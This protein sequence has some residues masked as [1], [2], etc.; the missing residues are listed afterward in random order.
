MPDASLSEAIRALARERRYSPA[1]V[2]RWLALAEP[3]ARACFELADGLKLGENQLRDLWQWADDI[4]ARD[5]STLADVFG[6]DDIRRVMARPLGRADR[7]K[8]VKDALRRRRFPQLLA[9][10]EKLAALADKLALPRGVRL[11]WPDMLEGDSLRIEF[12]AT[13]PATLAALAR[14]VAE[15]AARPEC[16]AMFALLDEAS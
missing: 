12:A 9:Q 3:D 15:A 2:E 1:F 6:H 10:E 5:A 16:A 13:D 4:G 14:A 7:L 8:A 11:T